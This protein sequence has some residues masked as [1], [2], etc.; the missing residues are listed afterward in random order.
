V[1]DNAKAFC[2]RNFKDFCFR[3]GITHIT[4]T[5]YYPQGSL[6]E[7]ANRNLKA[8]LKIFHHQSHNLWDEYL[9]WLSMA[10]NTAIHESTQATPDK[11]FLG[12]QLRCPLSVAWDLSPDEVDNKQDFWTSAWRSPKQA[13]DRVAARYNARRK[14]HTY[15]VGDMVMYRLKTLGSKANR[16]SAKFLLRWSRP[17]TIAKVLR[18]NVVLLANPETGVIVRKAHV[19]QLKSYNISVDC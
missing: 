19:S 1:T 15:N 10:F 7:L 11:L 2:S 9:P 8:A 13:R 12:R 4:T 18:P 6:V 5:P 17:V 3:W 14:A 16:I